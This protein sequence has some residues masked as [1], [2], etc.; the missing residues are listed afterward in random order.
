MLPDKI[1]ATTLKE[2][3]RA[4]DVIDKN[5][6]NFFS[7]TIFIASALLCNTVVQQI[8]NMNYADR[9]FAFQ[10]KKVCNFLIMHNL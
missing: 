2:I 4:F 5:A 10:Y 8:V 9:F 6:A 7:A 3:T 1:P